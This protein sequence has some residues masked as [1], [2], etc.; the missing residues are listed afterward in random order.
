MKFKV[1]IDCSNAAFDDN[2]AWEIMVILRKLDRAISERE[3][4]IPIPGGGPT[5]SGV[6]RA[7]DIPL[8]DTNGN[9]VGRAWLEE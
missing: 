3:R 5:I 7:E 2:P 4:L 6:S 1:E 9:R 8:I